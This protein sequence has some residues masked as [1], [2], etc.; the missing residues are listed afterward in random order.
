M[1]DIYD[2]SGHKM[3][4]IGQDGIVYNLT[5]VKLGRVDENGDV[6]DI[7]NRKIGSFEG[8]GYVY[9]GTRHIGTVYGDGRVCDYELDIIGNIKG[10]HIQSGGA[11]LLLLVR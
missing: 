11:A 10:D 2:E 4:T 7:A 1:G 6:F 5:R 3:A 9:E 8:N